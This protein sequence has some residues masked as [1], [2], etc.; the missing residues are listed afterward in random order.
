MVE[1]ALSRDAVLALLREHLPVLRERFG[2]AEL[3]LF[4]SH[5]RDEATAESDI[6]VLVRFDRKPET[7]WGC[8]AAQSYLADVFG[9]RVDMVER[10]R[11][12]KEYM[13]WVEVDAIDPANPR[14]HMPNGSRPKRWD[15]YIQEMMKYCRDVSEFT[16]DMG[17]EDYLADGKTMAAASFGLSQIGEAANKVPKHVRDMH[18]E[19][20]WG[21]MIGLRHL[22][23]HA[24]YEIEF[25]KLWEIIKI[26]VP[27]LATR[28]VPLLAEAQVEAEANGKQL[29]DHR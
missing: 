15:V 11:M 19:V 1:P 14:P 16:A 22:I 21:R 5:A 12:R 6:D 9:R 23:V 3:A 7:S 8:Y 27:E 20:D 29:Q 4:G 13:P 2:V 26:Y 24:Y 25:D 10:H 18:P 28:L 17:Y